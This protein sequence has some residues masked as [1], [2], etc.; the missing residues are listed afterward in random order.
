MAKKKKSVIKEVVETVESW[1]GM[2]PKA[3]K[4]AASKP[5]KK[6]TVVQDPTIPMEV[7]SKNRAVKKT[8]LAVS[9]KSLKKNTTKTVK[10]GTKPKTKT[11]P[12]DNMKKGN[13]VVK[14]R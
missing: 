10:S 5:T 4:A 6:T 7:P 2:G 9:K 8:A 13:K 14:K 3:T 1:V 12:P 11:A